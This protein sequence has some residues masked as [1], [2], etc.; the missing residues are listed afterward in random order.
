MLKVA[1][2]TVIQEINS[3]NEKIP[4][5]AL[6]P[7]ENEKQLF[8]S[9]DFSE[10]CFHC[11]EY[12]SL[13]TIPPSLKGPVN[14]VA[15]CQ[16][17]IAY[18]QTHHITVVYYSFDISNLIA[19]VVCQNLNLFGPSLESVLQC[20]HKFY[21]REID[22][23]PPGYS[24]VQLENEKKVSIDQATLNTLTFPVFMKPVCSSYGMF[25]APVDT[26]E[27]LEQVCTELATAYQPYWQMY[28]T[29]FQEFVDAT[30]YPLAVTSQVPLLV[31]ELIS[32]EPLTCDGFIYKG[33]INFL[34]LV[35]TV[36]AP[37]GSVDCYI[38]PSQV[39]EFQKQAIYERVTN[40]IQNSGLDNSFFSAEFWLQGQTPPILI[41]MNAR[42]S[43]TFSFLYKQ[44]INFNLPL[45]A[46]K[47]AQGICPQIPKQPLQQQIPTSIRLY[48]STRKSG[49]ASTLLDF[50]LAQQTLGSSQLITFNCKPEEQ[51]KNSSY[52]ST[53]LAE[54]NLFGTSQFPLK[55]YGEHLRNALLLERRSPAYQITVVPDLLLQGGEGLCYDSRNN[56]LFCLDYGNFQLIQL[57]LTTRNIQRFSLPAAFYGIAVSATGT[58]LLSGELG[59]MEFNLNTQELVPIVQEYQGQKLVCNDVIIDKTGCIWFNTI[60]E[61]TTGIGKEGAL[62]C[63][64]SQGQVQEVFK[65]FGYANSMGTSPDGRSLYVVDSLERVIHVFTLKSS[66]MEATL[67]DVQYHHKFIVANENEGVLDGLAVD[68][69]GYLWLTFWFGGKIICVH[70]RSEAR[71]R[72]VTLPVMNI[73]SVS[74]VDSECNPNAKAANKLFACSSVVSWLGG[75]SLSPWYASELKESKQGYLFEIDL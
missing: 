56:Q 17:A 18:A 48:L 44:S 38:F 26:P 34:G 58:V 65:G 15:F 6:L 35:D 69:A 61:D 63:C 25:C 54:L 57:C 31:E 52:H 53:P 2:V 70:P 36:E 7:S 27:Q 68:R 23:Y 4:V 8:S 41:E 64:N 28:S 74:V 71:L 45:A 32:G 66:K 1:T 37:N 22:S 24:F 16:D 13:K 42:M 10:Y 59:L 11:L 5:L 33:E 14:L 39:S 3:A 19:A 51:I 43:A 72:E 75:K 46:L 73:T 20:F 40:F 67:K 49:L 62:L 9:P 29:F 30:K 60:N 47:L 12:S 55:F 50:S 21:G